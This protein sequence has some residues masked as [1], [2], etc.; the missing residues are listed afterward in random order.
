M[1]N[2]NSMQS[3]AQSQLRSDASY[4]R[5]LDE[6]SRAPG[7]Y[8]TS[9]APVNAPRWLE[10]RVSVGMGAREV[11]AYN[12]LLAAQSR[13]TLPAGTNRPNTELYGTAPFMARGM[14]ARVNDQGAALNFVTG[15][16]NPKRSRIIEE[17]H[18]NTFQFLGVKP[19]VEST[20]R[21]RA[22]QMTRAGPIHMDPRAGVR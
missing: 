22:G 12:S 21:Q 7:K 8:S 5:L 10:G 1:G 2:N 4:L 13:V 3:L 11:D 6:Q 9:Y 16:K 20:L 18:W 17:R 14:G 19:R 15:V